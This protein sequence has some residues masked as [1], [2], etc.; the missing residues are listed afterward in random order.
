MQDFNTITPEAW[1]STD[2]NVWSAGIARFELTITGA[3]HEKLEWEPVERG[4]IVMGELE[5][6]VRT[7]K[8]CA[9]TKTMATLKTVRLFLRSIRLA[10]DLVIVHLEPDMSVREGGGVGDA[11]KKSIDSQT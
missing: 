5:Y 10:W 8:N 3:N 7:G 6:K 4:K 2:L 11:C 9:S 1:T